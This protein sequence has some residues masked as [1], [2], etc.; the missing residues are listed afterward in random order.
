MIHF[1]RHI[2]CCLFIAAAT[3]MANTGSAENTQPNVVIFLADDLGWADVGYHGE[4]VIETPSI[5]RLAA[6]GI[7]LDRFYSTPIC[8]PTRAA[9][10]TGRPAT[11][12]PKDLT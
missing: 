3:L 11:G 2:G 6:E 1:S 5:D 4:D 10:M 12:S 8:S 9:L 7:Q